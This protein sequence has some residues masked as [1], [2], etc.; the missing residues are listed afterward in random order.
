VVVI[1]LVS[2]GV[3]EFY[4]DRP[5]QAGLLTGFILSLIAVFGIDAVRADFQERRWAPLSQLAFLSLAYQTTLI[6]D[7]FLWLVT[8]ERPSNQARPD[9][10]VQARLQ[11]IRAAAGLEVTPGVA[12]LG[13]IEHDSYRRMLGQLMQDEAWRVC[14]R[15]ELDRCKW[16]NR[17]GIATW[18]AAML[19]TGEAADVLNRLAML[20]EQVSHV[21][22]AVESGKADAMNRW[23]YCHAEAVSVREDLIA[24]ARGLL[25]TEWLAFRQALAASHREELHRRHEQHSQSRNARKLLTEP[26]QTGSH[27][28][29]TPD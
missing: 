2:G 25:P 22:H 20:N 29:R 6:I 4:R 14:T 13:Q 23:L 26:L 11:A 5:L 24:T 1:E 18:A 15:M 8:G 17:D 10:A 21:Q 16:R 3:R 9:D 28:A 19:T 7:T 12:D 27:E